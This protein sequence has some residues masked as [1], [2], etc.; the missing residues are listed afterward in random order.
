M[1]LRACRERFSLHADVAQEA[2][3]ERAYP[4]PA[5]LPGLG[6]RV[7]ITEYPFAAIPLPHDVLRFTTLYDLLKAFFN[8]HHQSTPNALAGF[9]N[10][11]AIT[12]TDVSRDYLLPLNIIYPDVALSRCASVRAQ[13]ARDWATR[14]FAAAVDISRKVSTI[15]LVVLDFLDGLEVDRTTSYMRERPA[16]RPLTAGVEQDD[17]TTVLFEHKVTQ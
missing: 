8:A 4:T 1:R 11:Q 17:L 5:P 7:Q 13:Q 15:Q 16:V 12:S 9:N 10:S 2:E 14:C 6:P 3:A